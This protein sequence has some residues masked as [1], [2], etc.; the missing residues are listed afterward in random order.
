MTKDYMT[1]SKFHEKYPDLHKSFASLK[2]EATK[3]KD[4]GLTVYGAIIEKRISE[5]RPS[6]L[7][8]PTRY[9]DWLEAMQSDD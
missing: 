7:I 6:L 9:F 3:R 2:A 1:L 5:T 4:N 8:S